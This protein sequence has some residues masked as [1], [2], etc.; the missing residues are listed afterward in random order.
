MMVAIDHHEKKWFREDE[1]V[2]SLTKEKHS[3]GFFVK[4]EKLFAK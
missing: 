2:L 4:Q 1:S 3:M